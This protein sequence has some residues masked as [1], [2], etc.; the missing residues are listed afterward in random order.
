MPLPFLY[1]HT[2]AVGAYYYNDKSREM[3]VNTEYTLWNMIDRCNISMRQAWDDCNILSLFFFN[4][5]TQ[6]EPFP[7]LRLD[8]ELHCPLSYRALLPE[9]TTTLPPVTH[10]NNVDVKLTDRGLTLIKQW[11]IHFN[12]EEA[13]SGDKISQIGGAEGLTR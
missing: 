6:E 12:R 11:E 3:S 4:Y 2:H 8:Y 5:V 7:C 10:R 9:A 1:I 13:V